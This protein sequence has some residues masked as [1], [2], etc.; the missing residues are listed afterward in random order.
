MNDQQPTPTEPYPVRPSTEQGYPVQDYPVQR[1]PVQPEP[2]HTQQ[3]SSYT[4][5]LPVVAGQAQ[6]LPAR[7]RV[8]GLHVALAWVFTVLSLG[9]FLPWAIAATR[10]RSNALAIGVLNLLVGWTL[11]C[12]IAALVMAVMSEPAPVT[13][14]AYAAA[15]VVQVAPQLPPPGWYPDQRGGHRYWDGRGWTEHTA[16]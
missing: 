6:L 9:Y 5:P 10:Q 3:P 7:P 8:G 4:A 14:I 2:V 15:P 11:I 1:Y 16:P 13:T 12:W